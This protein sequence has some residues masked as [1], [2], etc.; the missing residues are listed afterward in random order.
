[1]PREWDS[2]L[3]PV[4][5]WAKGSKGNK[6]KKKNFDLK[7]QKNSSNVDIIS[8]LTGEW[9]PEHVGIPI[10]EHPEGSYYML[11]VHYNNPQ[12]RKVNDSSGVRL[13]LTPKLRAHEAGIL[14]T[15]V[16]VT[17][18]HVIPPRQKEYATAGYCTPHCTNAVSRVLYISSPL[19]HRLCIY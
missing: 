5:A 2:C 8:L 11:E 13:H 17:P 18:L 14:V 10:G 15:G 7:K 1:M 19:H 3:Q 9:L 4:L 16:A 6:K 12:L